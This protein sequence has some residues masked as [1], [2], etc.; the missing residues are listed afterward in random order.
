MKKIAIA[1]SKPAT[2]GVV[3][4]LTYF[5]PR[6]LKME[7]REFAAASTRQTFIDRNPEISRIEMFVVGVQ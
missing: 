3:Y 2:A 5:D 1:K 6:T 4:G 7:N